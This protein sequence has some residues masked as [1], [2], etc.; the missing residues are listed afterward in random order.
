MSKKTQKMYTAMVLHKNPQTSYGPMTLP[1]G[2][3]GLM[4]VFGTKGEAHAWEGRKA[5]LCE[6]WPS[7]HD[8]E[9]ESPRKST[10]SPKSTKSTKS[11]KSSKS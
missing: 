9:Y 3:I 10:K 6:L 8:V 11:A 1:K 4:F 7:V 5:K 2:C